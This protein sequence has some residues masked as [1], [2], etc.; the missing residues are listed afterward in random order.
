MAKITSRESKDPN[1]EDQKLIVHLKKIIEI[2][3]YCDMPKNN[4]IFSELIDPVNYQNESSKKLLSRLENIMDQ[5]SFSYHLIT[6]KII[7][8]ESE[9]LSLGYTLNSVIDKLNWLIKVNDDEHVDQASINLIE[10]LIIYGLCEYN[11]DQGHIKFVPDSIIAL[12]NFSAMI[13]ELISVW[14]SEKIKA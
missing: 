1:I 3:S 12:P 7:L 9:I 2:S 13:S 14:I 10:N 8:A 11:E 6:K 5:I 4:S